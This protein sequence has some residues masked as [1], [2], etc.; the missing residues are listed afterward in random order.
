MFSALTWWIDAGRRATHGDAAQLE[1]VGAIIDHQYNLTVI[2]VGGCA[3][4]E[5]EEIPV[6]SETCSRGEQVNRVTFDEGYRGARRLLGQVANRRHRDI[7]GHMPLARFWAVIGHGVV[8]A[9]WQAWS[10]LPHTKR[11]TRRVPRGQLEE[12]CAVEAGSSAM[13]IQGPPP[14]AGVRIVDL[15]RLGYGAQATALCGALGAEVIRIESR[16]RPDPVRIMPPFVPRP[17]EVE[18]TEPGLV[19]AWKPEMGFNRGGIFF[20]YNT[21]GKRS[22]TLNLKEPRG[23]DL[24]RRLIAQ[25]DVLTESFAAGALARMGLPWEELERLK[26]DLVY[27]SMSGFGHSGRDRA[28]VTL[29]PTAQALTGLT[30]MLGLPGRRP[31][32]W[33]FS[34]LDH[35]G[36]YLGAYAVLLGLRHRNRTGR[37]QHIDVAQI[38]PGIPLTGAVALDRQANGRPY[39][40]ADTPPGNRSPVPPMAPH[41][42]YRCAGN[43]AWIAIA[44][45]DD[46]DWQRLRKAMGEPAWARDASFDTVV[47]RRTY[48][49]ELDRNIEVLTRQQDRYVLADRLAVARV[50]AAPVQNARDRV[51][52][53]PQLRARDYFVDLSNSETGTWPSERPPFRLSASEVHA[54]GTIRRGPPCIGEDTHGVLGDI[55]GIPEDEIRLLGDAGVLR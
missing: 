27:V 51:E 30:Y 20:K 4:E 44:C 32:G 22:V 1:P 54:G 24:L 10:P 21:G 34:Y 25:A 42:A 9:H 5:T 17:G 15:T 31:A 47:G 3:G 39:R 28:H 26:P 43:D 11:G 18:Q 23:L 40:R 2:E 37:G 55:L 6:A 48:E 7:A 38:E 35:M 19:A 16:T 53:D 50:P 46:T 49:D 12:W 41:G 45:R 8:V 52:H 33:S 36:G 14:L 29:G 13:K